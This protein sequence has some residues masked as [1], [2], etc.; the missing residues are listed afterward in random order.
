M[1]KNMKSLIAT[2]LV[3][4]LILLYS[5]AYVYYNV[6]I[7]PL[8]QIWYIDFTLNILKVIGYIIVFIMF[9]IVLTAIT[10]S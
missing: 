8:R 1:Y 5:G 9:I 3:V 10:F 2:V 7:E 4:V 6:D